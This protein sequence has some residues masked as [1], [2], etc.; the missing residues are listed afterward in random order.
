MEFTRR[1]EDADAFIEKLWELDADAPDLVLNGHNHRYRRCF[2]PGT[3]V[4]NVQAASA[5]RFG[6]KHPAEFNLY[7]IEDGRLASIE[8]RIFDESQSGFKRVMAYDGAV[9]ESR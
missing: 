4:M 9:A 1:L 5:S 2:L 8:R 6:G 3:S 7:V